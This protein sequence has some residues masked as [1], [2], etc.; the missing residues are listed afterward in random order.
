MNKGTIIVLG[1]AIFFGV[2]IQEPLI[3]CGVVGWLM[4][5][6]IAQYHSSGEKANK[7]EKS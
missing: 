2:L 6:V 7:N 4:G 5:D 1:L 3:L